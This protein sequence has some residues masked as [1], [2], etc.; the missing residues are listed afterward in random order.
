MTD[1]GCRV[2]QGFDVHR[3]SDDPER[4][5]VLGGLRFEGWRGLEGHSDADVVTHT[6]IEALLAAAGLEDIGQLF[7]DD[8]PAWAG[9]D[10]MDLLRKAVSAVE[11]A[12]WTPVNVSCTVVIDKPKLAPRRAAMQELLSAAAGA[13]VTVTGRRSEGLGALGRGEGVAAW[14]VALVAR[15]GPHDR[16]SQHAGDDG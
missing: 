8:D 2:G 10:S 4:P 12:G 16:E 5:F 1:H 9:A 6:C 13:P 15:K 7:R 11:A 14:A 3:Y